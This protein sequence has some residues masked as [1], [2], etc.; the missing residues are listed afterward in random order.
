[1]PQPSVAALLI[2]AS[3][4]MAPVH[5]MVDLWKADRGGLGLL[6]FTCLICVFA[7]P[8]YGLILGM[9]FA[10]L[11]DASQTSLAES[12]LSFYRGAAVYSGESDPPSMTCTVEVDRH[13]PRLSLRS[14]PVTA[15][16]GSLARSIMRSQGAEPFD[17]NVLDEAS[18]CVVVYEPVG[19][20]VYLT[21]EKHQAR[22]KVLLERQPKAI[23]VSLDLTSRVDK[24]GSDALGKAM[25]Q[26]AEKDLQVELCLPA[27]LKNTVVGK[28][29][30]VEGLQAAGH[31]HRRRL[32]AL[33]AAQ[34]VTGESEVSTRVN[35]LYYPNQG[36]P[37]EVGRRR[38]AGPQAE[39][40]GG[41]G[42]ASPTLARDF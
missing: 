13:D 37:E 24:D 25:K 31:V 38:L 26:I 9:V 1:L 39:S 21:Q 2:F 28:A 20:L 29:A 22:L 14:S 34:T 41:S 35:A 40:A 33:R 4:R 11:R 17:R 10:L 42:A 36:W 27:A 15:I 19:P 8:V 5:Y 18:G 12:R 23:V 30:W 7:D 16:L 6:V 3:V 32:D